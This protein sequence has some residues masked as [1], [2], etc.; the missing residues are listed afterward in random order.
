MQFDL[1]KRQ[2]KKAITLM[3]DHLSKQ[4]YSP[5]LLMYI[6]KYAQRKIKI[7]TLSNPQLTFTRKH[8]QTHI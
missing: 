4:F 7:I 1:T 2:N 5:L 6:K 3:S 8:S